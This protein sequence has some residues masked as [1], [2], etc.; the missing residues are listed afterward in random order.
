MRKRVG[1]IV[2]VFCLTMLGGARAEDLKI[3]GKVVDAADKPIAGVDVAT[4]WNSHAGALQPNDAA[5]TGSDG[6]F[7]LKVQYYGRGTALFALD[8]E[9]KIGGVLA[10][11]PKSP[12]KEVQVK[13][14]P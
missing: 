12:G 1:I 2:A 10:I 4:F 7:S 6:K 14:G 8:K 9:R 3:T 5:T 13:L 11:D